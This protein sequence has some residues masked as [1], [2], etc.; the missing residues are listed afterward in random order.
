MLFYS[1]EFA[2]SGCLVIGPT[3]SCISFGVFLGEPQE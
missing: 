3:G 2:Q 1:L